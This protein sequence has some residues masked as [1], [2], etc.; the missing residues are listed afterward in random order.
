MNLTNRNLSIDVLRGWSIALIFRV[1]TPGSYATTYAPLLHADWHGFTP[2]DWVFPT[3]LFVMG[4]SM[5]FSFSKSQLEENGPFLKKVL[6]RALVIF[7]IGYILFW[8]P[9]MKFD[10]DGI[11]IAIPFESTRIFE[12]YKE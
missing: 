10:A 9:F 1:V 8:F 6:F 11:L 12:S 7:L 2:T 4:N 5:S 3:F